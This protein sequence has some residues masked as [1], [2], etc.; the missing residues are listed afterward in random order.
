MAY[1]RHLIAPLNSGLQ[2]N[3]E[4][5]LI[6]D[7]AFA[8]LYNAYVFRGKVRKRFG[9]SLT[10][11]NWDP[12]FPETAPL[13]GRVRIPLVGAGVGITDAFGVAAGTVP[14]SIWKVGQAFSV[15]NTIFTIATAGAVVQM[16]RTDGSVEVATFDTTNGAYAITIVADPLTQVYFYPAEPIMGLTQY[17]KGPIN[18]HTAYAFDTQ[19]IYQYTG[20]SWNKNGPTDRVLLGQ[21]DGAGVLA[22][23]VAGALGNVGQQFTIGAVVFTVV[24]SNTGVLAMNRNPVGGTLHTFDVS[25]GAFNF[26]GE[27]INTDVYFYSSGIKF[28][29]TNSQF[30]WATTWNGLTS[31]SASMYVSNYNAT[32]GV[33]GVSDDY[34][35]RFDGAIWRVFAPEFF[36][37]H[38]KVVNARIILSFKDRLILLSTVEQNAVGTL[39]TEYGN[40]C[41]FSHNGSPLAASAWYEHNQVGWSG[42]GWID[43]TTE[44]RIISAEFIRDRLIVYFERSTWEL[45]YTGNQVQ[46]FVW[47]KINTELGAEATFSA[48]PFDKVVLSVGNT[49]VHACNGANVER[50][51]VKVPDE[52]FRLRS[53]NNGIY[54]VAGIRDFSTEFVYWIYPGNDAGPYSDV[55]PNKVFIYNYVNGTWSFNDDCITAFGYYE[56]KGDTTWISTTLTWQQAAFGWTS[57]VTQAD[58]RYVLGGNQQGYIFTIE[59]DTTT[60][61]PAMQI[62]DI[63][64]AANLTTLTIVDHTLADDDFIKIENAKRD[65]G[66]VEDLD[67]LND[68]IYPVTVIDADTISIGDEPF[69]GVYIG[70]GTAARVS[71]IKILSKEWNPYIQSGQLVYLAKIDFCVQKTEAGE[72]TV[73]YYPSSVDISMIDEAEG[74]GANLG[75]NILET[76]PYALVPLEEFQDRLWHSVYFQGEGSTVQIYLYMD[77]DQMTDVDIAESDFQLE[78]LILYTMK[79]GSGME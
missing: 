12:L 55:F 45:V 79:S 58:F 56:Q 70:A 23:V 32:V 35:L 73:D 27:A 8:E 22:G 66:G 4:S 76:S 65:D 74:S 25:T 11:E 2:K 75:T 49:G 5:W 17:D 71:N 57:G 9:S 64:Y 59:A 21:T 34:M 7:D 3:L 14:G 52:I 26:T 69:D 15:G 31:D 29:G 13:F 19:Y 41:R 16:L 33:P 67:E 28:D 77:D 6:P 38:D 47:Q 78:G 50:I 53:E 72:L 20:G 46:P 61:A 36:T 51:D 43:A 37:A 39:N 62:S 10:G 60:N 68:N 40:R 42:G 24:N 1:D 48:V 30:F 54:R 63:Q 18:D 44:E